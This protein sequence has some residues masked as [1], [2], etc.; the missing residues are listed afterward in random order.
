MVTVQHRHEQESPH[1]RILNFMVYSFPEPELPGGRVMA[2]GNATMP[3]PK[4]PVSSRGAY[5]GSELFGVVNREASRLYDGVCSL[6]WTTGSRDLPIEII[7]NDTRFE[8]TAE[9]PGLDAG[10]IEVEL[11][12]RQLTIT[13]EKKMKPGP[14][15][16]EVC[17]SER[18]YGS[19]T[20]TVPLR[21]G[22][23]AEKI[24]AIFANGI[25]TVVM[26]KTTEA[27]QPPRKIHVQAR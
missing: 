24:E 20:R 25:L 14:E 22:V 23:D 5:W 1:N 9:L 16:K 7:E 8:L 13:A 26:P 15:R 2:E 11:H 19:F 18:R 3:A 17:V 27:L 21:E 6:I 10:D 4:Q 12:N